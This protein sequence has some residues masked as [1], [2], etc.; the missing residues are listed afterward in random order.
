VH[1]WRFPRF[2]THAPAVRARKTRACLVSA[3]PVVL[4]R[5]R[6]SESE[7][8]AYDDHGSL[9]MRTDSRVSLVLREPFSTCVFS[10]SRQHSRLHLSI[11]YPF[12]TVQY[13]S[14]AEPCYRHLNIRIGE[15]ATKRKSERSKEGW[16]TQDKTR[17][18]TR[19]G[20]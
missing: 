7:G 14:C 12:C 6:R 20:T 17:E 9:G 18:R 15:L 16:E 1:L 11:F 4:F 2:V 5:T 13:K 10:D 8:K 3:P 19:R